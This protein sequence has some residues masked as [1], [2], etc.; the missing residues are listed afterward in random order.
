VTFDE[1]VRAFMPPKSKRAHL[2]NLLGVLARTAPAART[3]LAEALHEAAERIRK[4][5]LIILL[6]DLLA[7]PEDVVKALHHM[8]FRGHDLII[9]QV[10]DHS[11]VVFDFDGQVRFHEPESGEKLE[12]DPQSLRAGYLAAL[13]A[14]IEDYRREC[15]AVRADFATVHNAMTFDKALTEFLVQR[16]SHM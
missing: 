1:K 3:N 9:F 2:M 7:D 10:L 4:R 13:E 15:R 6:S 5:S 12:A 11:E 8:R 16:R 14:F